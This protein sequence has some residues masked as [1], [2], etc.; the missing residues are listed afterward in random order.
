MA[1]RPLSPHLFVYRFAYTMATSIF[2]RVTGVML[3][4]GLLLLVAWLAALAAGADAYAAFARCAASW[5]V[6]VIIGLL[7]IAFCYHTANG[8]R[9]LFWDIGKGLERR[10]ARASARVVVVVTVLSSALLLYLVFF[11][12]GGAS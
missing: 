10:Q 8:V 11:S 3:S 2:N 9:H 7:L 4:M 1:S 5:P 12:R 6:Q